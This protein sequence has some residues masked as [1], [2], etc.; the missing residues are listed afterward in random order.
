MRRS[1]ETFYYGGSA[2][3]L[4]ALCVKHISKV[5]EDGNHGNGAAHNLK[6]SQERKE[7]E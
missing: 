4:Q 6:K 5:G 1:A 3:A 7:Q 2:D